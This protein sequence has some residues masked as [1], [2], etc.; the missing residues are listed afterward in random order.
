M[1]NKSADVYLYHIRDAI[2]RIE[3]FMQGVDKKDFFNDDSMVA[4]AVVREFEIIGEAISQMPDEFRTKHKTVPWQVIV[5]MRNRLI[6]GYFSVD[7]D[8]VWNAAYENLPKLKMQI[9]ELIREIE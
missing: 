4:A 3:R 2:S 6:H 1:E 5:D 7:Y 9:A 8:I